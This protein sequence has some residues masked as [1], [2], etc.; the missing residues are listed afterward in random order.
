[1]G[2]M[3]ISGGHGGLARA[4]V[5][6]FTAAGWEADAPS[7]AELDVGDRSAVRRW[8]DEH[9]PYDL[10]VCAAG[11]TRDRPFLKQTEKEWDEVM[12]VNVTGAAWCARCAAAAMAREKRE[13]QVVMVGSYAALRPAPSQA[14][15]AASKSALE[16]LVKSLAREWGREGIRVEGEREG[17]CFV[18]ACSGQVQYAGAGRGVYSV[19]A[20]SP[21]GSLRAGV[22]FG[23]PDC[24]I[25]GSGFL[26]RVFINDGKV[27]RKKSLS[28][29]GCSMIRHV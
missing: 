2:R 6:C 5:E 27:F 1:M 25:M 17:V 15:Y 12:N 29:Q 16:G 20:G 4:A 19:F 21:H 7:H 8:F 22:R 3:F 28:S 11:I 14:A 13:G 10:A 24:L 26:I 18:Q 23:Q 9:A